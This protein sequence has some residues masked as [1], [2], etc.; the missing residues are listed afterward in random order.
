MLCA[1]DIHKAY[2]MVDRTTMDRIAS[3]LGIGDNGFW[4]LL[5]AARDEGL[6]YITGGRG[7]SP[8]F[9]TSRGIKQGCPASPV[10]FALLLSGLERRLLRLHSAA[11]PRVGGVPRPLVSYA[12]DIKLFAGTPAHMRTLLL[13]VSDFLAPLGLAIE[14]DKTKLLYMNAKR[15]PSF[16]L[17]GCQTPLKVVSEL[18]FLG[19]MV[20]RTGH[21]SSARSNFPAVVAR[22]CS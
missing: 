6:V 16:K 1:L 5:V 12:D 19:L 4:R 20:N 10:V 17:P 9:T 18:K 3:R 14:W 2:D 7:L 13:A 11:V 22:L 8:P 15:H 21:I